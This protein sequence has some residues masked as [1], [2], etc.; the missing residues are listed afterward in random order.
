MDDL[1]MPHMD[2][3]RGA[4]EVGVDLMRFPSGTDSTRLSLLAMI[5][6]LVRS[7][8]DIPLRALYEVLTLLEGAHT[9]DDDARGEE[10]HVGGCPGG[11]SPGVDTR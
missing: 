4:H 11:S 7:N 6:A 5:D 10:D 8:D 9:R 1:L 3:G 2:P